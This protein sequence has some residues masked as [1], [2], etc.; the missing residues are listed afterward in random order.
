MSY[1]DVRGFYEEPDDD[2]EPSY[3]CDHCEKPAKEAVAITLTPYRPS[4]LRAS[5]GWICGECADKL[6]V[7]LGDEPNRDY[8][9]IR[10]EPVFSGWDIASVV[11]TLVALV[12]FAVGGS[13]NKLW[14]MGSAIPAA[15]AALILLSIGRWRDRKKGG[16]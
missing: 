2:I 16:Q 6:R 4:D 14:V 10:N 12:L 3:T 1:Q 13:L 5:A 8:L 7:W 15:L 11:M 9:V